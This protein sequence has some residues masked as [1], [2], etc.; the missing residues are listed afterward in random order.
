MTQKTTTLFIAENKLSKI[1]HELKTPLN[2]INTLVKM[3]IDDP[4]YNERQKSFLRV[5]YDADII[6][7]TKVDQLIDFFKIKSEEIV[8]KLEYA[9]FEAILNALQ[10]QFIS[11]DKKDKAL[12]LVLALDER[13][14]N[15]ITDNNSLTKAL[16]YLLDNAIKFTDQ[17]TITLSVTQQV[18]SEYPIIIQLCDT[19]IGISPEKHNYIFEDFAQVDESI[20]R[21]YEGLGLGLTIAKGFIEQISGKISLTSEQGKG[22]CFQVMLPMSLNIGKKL[23][24]LSNQPLIVN[25]E[26][27]LDASCPERMQYCCGAVLLVDDDVISNFVMKSILETRNVKFVIAENG[28]VAIKVLQDCPNI[29]MLITDLD[30]PVINGYELIK[31]VRADEKLKNLPIIVVTSSEYEKSIVSFD[32]DAYMSKPIEVD[33]I[34]TILDNVLTE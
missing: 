27:R 32:V 13:I 15:I 20:A 23:A 16:S 31:F 3:M 11:A 26:A 25:K 19:G 24:N 17:G 28:E 2:A 9:D 14:Q 5:I 6:L 33:T 21:R 29:K 18:D 12:E 34:F 22:A 30:M 1:R 10:Q 7:E 8:P 4:S